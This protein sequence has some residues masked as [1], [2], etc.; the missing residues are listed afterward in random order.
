MKNAFSKYRKHFIHEKNALSKI[1][2]CFIKDKKRLIRYRKIPVF[3][4]K[5]YLCLVSAGPFP[6]P[7]TS[8]FAR[9]LSCDGAIGA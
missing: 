2:E 1:K 6:L 9:R 3:I 8:R 4:L 7:G 5:Y